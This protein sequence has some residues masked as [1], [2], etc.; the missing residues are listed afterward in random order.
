MTLATKALISPGNSERYYKSVA[1]FYKQNTKTEIDDVYRF[2]QA[3]GVGHCSGGV[4]ANA[5]G[6]NGQASA[7]QKPLVRDADHGKF[8]PI[9]SSRNLIPELLDVVAAMI[10]WLEKGDAPDQI[11]ATKWVGDKDTADVKFTRPLCMVSLCDSVRC[12][13]SSTWSVPQTSCLSGTR[14]RQYHS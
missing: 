4:G 5:F 3:P 2:F 14:E 10:R 1:N 6:A 12:R 9:S 7:G 8:A 11:I 13:C